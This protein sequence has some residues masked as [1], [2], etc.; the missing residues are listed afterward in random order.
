MIKYISVLALLIFV[1]CAP[2]RSVGDS[3]NQFQEFVNDNKTAIK[4]DGVTIKDKDFKLQIP[5]G[6]V[7]R[8]TDIGSAFVHHLN[9]KGH[10][11]IVL[12][13]VP[14][15]KSTAIS[16]SLGLSYNDFIALCDKENITGQLEG[17]AMNKH[18]L[19]G[20][21]KPNNGPFYAIYLNVRQAEMNKFN[22]AISSVQL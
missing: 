16:K 18:R 13:Y 22:Y 5:V 7:N 11:T 20:L 15:G 12:L 6:L 8:S 17:I 10:Q 14:N 19:Y 1:G 3:Q 21:H 2:K 9:F 4:L